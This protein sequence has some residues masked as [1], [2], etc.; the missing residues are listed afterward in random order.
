MTENIKIR[1]ATEDDKKWMRETLL[2][3]NYSR[4]KLGLHGADEGG[5]IPIDNR[6]KAMFIATIGE[7]ENKKN[8]GFTKIVSHSDHN[9]VY[10]ADLY[11]IKKYRKK[12]IAQKLFDFAFEWSHLEW[13]QEEMDVYTIDNKPMAKFL[14]KNGFN[15]KGTFKDFYK[16]GS[17]RF[18]QT[19]W[20]KKY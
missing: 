17:K 15:N 16:R 2:Y 14:K 3:D 1:Y 4:E 19:Y 12:G 8:I 5:M 18:D 13:S 11:V 7:K 6:Y 20:V 9:Q 10:L